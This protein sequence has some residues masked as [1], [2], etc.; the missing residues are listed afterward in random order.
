MEGLESET[1]INYEFHV[2]PLNSYKHSENDNA[3]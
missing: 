3:E 1:F 2:L